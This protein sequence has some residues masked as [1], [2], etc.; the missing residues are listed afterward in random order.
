MTYQDPARTT[1]RRPTRPRTCRI[2]IR[3]TR[4][5]GLV[6][7]IA[8]MVAALGYRA[9]AALSSTV[10]LP[11]VVPRGEHRGARA[12]ALPSVV[13][14]AGGE[15]A[16]QIGH[17]QIQA[18]PN[19]HAAAIASVARVMT[20]YLVLG[21]HPLYR[22]EWLR[23]CNRV[24]CRRPGADRRSG[25]A[26]PLVREHRHHT[27]RDGAVAG[28]VHNTDT[29]LGHNRFVGV[30]T[31]SDNAAGGCFV[32]R[33]IRRING[34]R[35]TI[36]G[37][38][39]GQPGNDRVEADLAVGVAMVDRIAGNRATPDRGQRTLPPLPA[40]GSLPPQPAPGSRRSRLRFHVRHC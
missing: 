18:A 12:G 8:M 26:P 17:S 5:P 7:I 21:A 30:K 24:D 25:D 16:V 32:F 6:V 20:A 39:L 35:T 15:S 34:K 19:Q 13:S 14:P 27:E 22:P 31:G 10:A 40:F 2:Q 9:L 1:T 36:T 28:T 38:V 37:V 4:V 29:L 33:A 11:I 3:S 23:R